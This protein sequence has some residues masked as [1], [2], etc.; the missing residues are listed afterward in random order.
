M[1]LTRHLYIEEEVVAALQFCVLRGRAVEAVFWCEELLYS[2]MIDALLNALREIWRNGFGIGALSWF[3]EFQEIAHEEEVEFEQLVGLVVWLCRLGL[4]GCRDITYLVLAGSTAEAEQAAYSIAPKGV[5]GVDAYFLACVD[6]GRAISAWRALAS[7]RSGVLRAA[8]EAKHGK[9]GLDA[10]DILVEYPA[11]LVAALCLVKGELAARLAEP[12]HGILSEVDRARA[13]WEPLLGRRSRRQYPIPHECL[14]WLTE[15]GAK[16]VYET[17]EKLLRGSLERPGKLWGSVY[18]DSVADAVGGWEAVR[19][20]PEVRMA[21]YDEHFPDDT[22]DEW[23]TADRELSHGR[24]ASQPGT[25]PEAERFLRSWFGKL[26]SA[27]IWNGFPAAV[28]GLSHIKTWGDIAPVSIPDC[29]LNLIRLTRRV[30]TV[31]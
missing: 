20:D 24:G 17:S 2:E 16:T 18:W 31:S 27:V 28:K 3:R 5:H 23:S 15:R 19:S 29:P 9:A 30:I 26:P 11:L 22:P 6:Q 1:P 7:T 14:Y 4:K 13:E 10:C 25:V 8:A 21:F 12:I